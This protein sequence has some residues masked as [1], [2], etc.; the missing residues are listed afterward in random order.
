MA[1]E[2]RFVCP[3]CKAS[4][5]WQVAPVGRKAKC[6]CGAPLTVPALP[7]AMSKAGAQSSAPAQPAKPS[8]QPGTLGKGDAPLTA[9]LCPSCAKPLKGG[10]VLC[11]ECGFNIKKGKA[12][13]VTRGLS[14][15]ETD[16]AQAKPRVRLTI[17]R[18]L[19]ILLLLVGIVALFYALGIRPLVQKRTQY[20]ALMTEHTSRIEQFANQVVRSSRLVAAVVP[21]DPII[22]TEIPTELRFGG[23]LLNQE[24]QIV[25]KANV[26]YDLQQNK[27]AAICYGSVALRACARW[28]GQQFVDFRMD[29]NVQETKLADLV[30]QI[31]CVPL[32]AGQPSP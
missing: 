4:F 7:M 22:I 18:P 28:D 29:G 14:A 25:G 1:E 13:I 21:V 10:A 20:S 30:P 32:P 6:R 11:I 9:E 19:L 12:T 17:P 8:K 26:I 16:D 2:P 27:I 23:A 31:D 15:T 5:R 24:G 3:S